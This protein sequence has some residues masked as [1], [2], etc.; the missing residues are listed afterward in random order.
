MQAEFNCGDLI[1]EMRLV[2]RNACGIDYTRFRRMESFLNKIPKNK[3]VLCSMDDIEFIM[4]LPR[5][6]GDWDA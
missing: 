4:S 5:R 1:R 3:P 6:S 2:D